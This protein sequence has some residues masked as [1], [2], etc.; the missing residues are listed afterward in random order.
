MGWFWHWTRTQGLTQC[1]SWRLQS[2]H[3]EHCCYSRCSQAGPNSNDPNLSPNS[4]TST[5]ALKL[6]KHLF[7]ECDITFFFCCFFYLQNLTVMLCRLLN[8]SFPRHNP[9]LSRRANEP[10]DAGWRWRGDRLNFLPP[11]LKSAEQ[12]ID[13]SPALLFILI[14]A[15]SRHAAAV[16]PTFNLTSSF[17]SKVGLKKN[18][19]K[20]EGE[21]LR[22]F[23]SNWTIAELD[24]E[25]LG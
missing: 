20:K 17:S 9:S 18:E 1:K 13:S 5:M 8:C 15:D 22:F 25:S 21:M 14:A 7:F 3:S 10:A 23:R 16:P 4:E 12:S 11:G 19:K 2:V 24:E 6:M